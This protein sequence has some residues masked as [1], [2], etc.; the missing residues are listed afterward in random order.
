MSIA[1][2][3]T[4]ERMAMKEPDEL[5]AQLGLHAA[6]DQDPRVCIQSPEMDPGLLL[7]YRRGRLDD[8]DAEKV[9]AHLVQCTH[10]RRFVGDL[11]PASRKELRRWQGKPDGV[12]MQW[13]VV[14]T[15]L[16]AGV[17]AVAF[18]PRAGPPPGYSA[19]I[20]EGGVKLN[21]SSAPQANTYFL[22][23]SRLRWRLQPAERLA[24]PPE[25]RAFAVEAGALKPLP[26]DALRATDGGGW[27]LETPARAAL[28]ATYGERELIIAVSFDGDALRALDGTT[29]Q[30]ERDNTSIQYY[31]RVV[32]YRADVEESP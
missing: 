27:R 3:L 15:L 19:G 24:K 6:R 21:K 5:L 28:G 26:D 10:C 14:M 9:R 25:A 31:S 4:M 22:P 12:P 23:E 13:M 30:R 17:A 16:I 29:W 2:P 7:A 32:R 18:Y 1:T 20:V 8:T 11:Q